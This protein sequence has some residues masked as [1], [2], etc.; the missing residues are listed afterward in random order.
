MPRTARSLAP[1][2]TLLLVPLLGCGDAVAP[3]PI[4]PGPAAHSTVA[5]NPQPEPPARLTVA[6]DARGTV[7]GRMTG[8]VRL[9]DGVGELTIRTIETRTAGDVLHLEQTWEIHPPDPIEP[10]ELRL[11]GTVDGTEVI[12]NGSGSAGQAHVTA[13]LDGT[14]LMGDLSIVGFNPQPEPPAIR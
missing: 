2:S 10:F 11:H 12:L 3:E 6:F 13:E 4:A 9:P 14:T 1:L 7:D 8:S 5:F